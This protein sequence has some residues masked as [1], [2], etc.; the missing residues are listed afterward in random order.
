MARA[1]KERLRQQELAK[2]QALERLRDE[3]NAAAARGEV[4]HSLLESARPSTLCCSCST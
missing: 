2:R 3:E 4:G 1:E